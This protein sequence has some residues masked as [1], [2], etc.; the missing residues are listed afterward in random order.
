MKLLKF[1][2]FVSNFT[3]INEARV[4]A[5]PDRT[6]V[7]NPTNHSKVP[8]DII[9][10]TFNSCSSDDM[11]GEH[12]MFFISGDSRVVEI[13][14]EEALKL[15]KNKDYSILRDNE[16]RNVFLV[17]SESKTGILT[18]LKKSN[19]T[20]TNVK[21]GLVVYFYYSNIHEIPS[22]QNAESIIKTLKNLSIPSESLDPKS[23][24]EI[25][26]YLNNLFLDKAAI[27]SLTD[28][29]SVGYALSN[30]LDNKKHIILRSNLFNSIRRLGNKLTR[31]PADKWC[32]GDIYITD[33]NY[34]GVISDYVSEIEKNIQ[35]DSIAKL[36]DLFSDEMMINNEKGSAI[37]S[38]VAIS[39]KQ[40]EAQAGKA[41]E[42]LKTL[43][44]D[45]KQYNVT[46]AEYKL[47]DSEIE[48]MIEDLRKKIADACSKSEITINLE[49]DTNYKNS[50]PISLRNKFA[51]LKVT[52]K[53][54][55]NPAE[56]DD[57]ILK[58]TAF[59]M[60]LTGVN[61]TFFKFMG[62]S[63][64]NAKVDKFPKGEMIYL[65]DHG[66]GD[67][68]SSIDIVDRNSNAEVMFRFRI[69]KGEYEKPI[70]LKC[71]P[72]GGVQSTLE[73]EKMK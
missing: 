8:N 1:K 17:V 44:K 32:P 6:Y 12:S 60:S 4:W 20:T 5:H 43:T 70:I 48:S 10:L 39:L 59:A 49:Q 58:S 34:L 42:F 67:K 15:L 18:E 68:R 72:N 27:K 33:R 52:A 46:K 22:I 3:F 56:I 13:D 47:D 54:L 21:E 25:Q 57:N 14:H 66:L 35:D 45:Q 51:S 41:K 9:D 11:Q 2:D 71:R 24:R 36:N 29:W 50:N 26:D 64:G 69:K 30:I 73:I 31:L 55:E 7:F 63:K 38:V 28:F 19:E 53:L 37:G 62:S 23:V 61:P 40:E 16:G 65:L